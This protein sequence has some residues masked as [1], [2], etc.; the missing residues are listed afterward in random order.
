MFNI[1][2]CLK[3]EYNMKEIREQKDITYI[4]KSFSTD[5]FYGKRY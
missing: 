5:S 4:S 3:N 1:L 2:Y